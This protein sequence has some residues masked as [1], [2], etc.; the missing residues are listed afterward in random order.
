MASE[1]WV[2][3]FDHNHLRITRIIRSLRVLGLEEEARVFFEA[4]KS[5][6]ESSN[7]S[8]RS[9]MYWTRA[10]IRPLDISPEVEPGDE[11]TV[12][13]PRFLR[14]FEKKRR[15][16]AEVEEDLVEQLPESQN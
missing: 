12:R 5:V 4:L 10:A 6:Q 9:L 7:I 8:Q 13:G 15:E 14:E 3:M 1:N 16:E 11:N 2:C